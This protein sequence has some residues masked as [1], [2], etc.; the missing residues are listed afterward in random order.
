MKNLTLYREVG[1]EQTTVVLRFDLARGL[2][3]LSDTTANVDD[4]T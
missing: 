3:C 2:S 1:R 4:R